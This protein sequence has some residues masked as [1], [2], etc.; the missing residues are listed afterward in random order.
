MK[1]GASK[2]DITVPELLRGNLTIHDPL[3]ARVF[4][5]DD[6]NKAVAIIALDMCLTF[7]P[8]VRE[9]IREELGIE[10]VLVNCTHNHSD[11]RSHQADEWNETV[12]QSIFEAVEEAYADRASVSLHAGRVSVEI[13]SNRYGDD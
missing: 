13:G 8:E 7:F 9:R 10:R 12:G 4:V 1:A 5:L 6:R 3:F 2:R 11:A